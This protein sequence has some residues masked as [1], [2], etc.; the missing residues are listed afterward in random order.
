MSE[1]K[2]FGPM[3]TLTG[4]LAVAAGI[5]FFLF[6]LFIIATNQPASFDPA[7]SQRHPLFGRDDFGNALNTFGENI[8]REQKRQKAQENLIWSVVIAAGGL[9]VIAIAK[10]APV[11]R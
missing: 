9:G 11:N 6:Q 7:K 4:K 2:G 8:I 5:I 3:L 10:R 1:E